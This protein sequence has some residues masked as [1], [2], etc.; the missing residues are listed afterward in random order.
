MP[1]SAR[2]R[3]PGR[4]KLPLMRETLNINL[5]GAIATIEAA[6]PIFRAQGV[7]PR[8]R[9]HVGRG[10]EGPARLRRLQREQGGPA[11]LP[12][13]AARRTPRRRRRRDRTR[14]GIHRHRHQ[15]QQGR[16]AVPDRRRPGRGHHGPH[17]RAPG[18]QALGAGPAVDDHRPV[19]QDP[20]GRGARAAAAS[21]ADEEPRPWTSPTHRASRN[22]R[23]ACSR[24]WTS[25]SI[26]TS[27]ASSPRSRRNKAQGNGW[28]PT[29]VM[30]ELKAEARAAGLWNLWLPESEHGA[31]LT[32]PRVRAARRDHR[33]LAHR[34]RGAQLLGARHR[35]HGSARALRQR[36]AAGALAQAAA[37]PARSARASR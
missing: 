3:P 34:A 15:S 10:F 17:D 24:S 36:R 23:R 16:A 8:R 9:H 14:A 28:V 25:T 22:C 29:Q 19:A 11:S 32:Q 27:R 21:A 20:A 30:E 31:G 2:S 33:A 5:V 13:V 37:A 18:G 4:G 12:A 7:G 6:L 26:R 35:Q 1:A